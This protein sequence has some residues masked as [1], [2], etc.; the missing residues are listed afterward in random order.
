MPYIDIRISKPVDIT[1]KNKLQSEIAGIMDIIPGKT[2][3]NTTICISDNHTIYRDTKPIEA[4][5]IDIR[6]Y[7]ES[8][9]DSKSIF[10]DRL[11]SIF[12]NELGIP[13]SH[14]QMN[15]VELPCWASNGNL[16]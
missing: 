13:P 16:F 14:V 10:A 8:P 11:F 4:A 9:T 6:L 1:Q 15:F 3:D 12:Y 5:F 2:A 7:K